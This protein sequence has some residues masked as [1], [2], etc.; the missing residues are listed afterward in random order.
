MRFFKVVAL[1][2]FSCLLMAGSAFG[3]CT[4]NTTA[5]NFGNYDVLSGAANDATGAITVT[6]NPNENVDVAI[7]ASPTSGGFSPR[8]IKHSALPDL[9]NYNVFTNNGRATI[10]GDGTGATN[11]VTRNNVGAGGYTFT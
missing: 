5:V 7:G 8:Q 10:W 6:C 2:V 1:A 11:V 3:V 4:V 9:L